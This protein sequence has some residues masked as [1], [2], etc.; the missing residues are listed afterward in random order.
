MFAKESLFYSLTKYLNSE[1]FLIILLFTLIS[2]R[3]TVDYIGMYVSISLPGI[4]QASLS[5]IFGLIVIPIT[6]FFIYKKF[7]EILKIPAIEMLLL[8]IL[9]DII[10]IPITPHIDIKLAIIEVLR[11]LGIVFIYAISYISIKSI[12]NF[13]KL[14]YVILLSSFVSIVFTLFQLIFGIGYTDV[15][16][17][18][19]RIM[20]AFTHPNVY[21][22]YLLSVLS[23]ILILIVLSKSKK[24]SLFLYIALSIQ[25][26]ALTL[27]FTRIAWLMGLFII[28]SFVFIRN[29]ILVIPI[30]LIVIMSYIMIPQIHSRLHEAITLS[31][32]S[33]LVWRY[34]LW[35][36]TI[37][38]TISNKD[39]IF[40]NGTASF[41]NFAESIRGNLFGDLEPHNEFVKAF[42]ENGIIGL[43]I[44]IMYN[45]TFTFSLITSMHKT[46]DK[47]M[48][49][50]FYILSTLFIALIIASIT[51]HILSSTPLEWVVMALIGGAFSIKAHEQLSSSKQQ[52]KQK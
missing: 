45:I 39:T 42:V 48:K 18:E 40:G 28:L 13:R 34:N 50:I 7:K 19:L 3:T 4:G 27:T 36:D 1:N 30:I 38:Y 44:F 11:L 21:G 29:K 15:A 35:H 14:N 31:P 33:S 46:K 22:V 26:L 43:V 5:R 51:D 16:F 32:D 25:F 23:S 49:N 20:G 2:I 47:K 52:T 37:F 24:E 10:T 12:E 17:S 41:M 9:L 6:I 8:I